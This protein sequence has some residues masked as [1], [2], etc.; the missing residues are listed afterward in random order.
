MH[1]LVPILARRTPEKKHDSI[2]NAFEVV[3]LVDEFLVLDRAEQVD[4][5]CRVDEQK[6]EHE[7]D[8]VCDLRYDVE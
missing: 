4:T 6:Q 7:T 2:A 5:E 1:D 3:L 8:E